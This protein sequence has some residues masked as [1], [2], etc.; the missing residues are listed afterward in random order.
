[1]PDKPKS[2][3]GR[4]ST[5]GKAEKPSTLLENARGVSPTPLTHQHGRAHYAMDQHP[6]P[7]DPWEKPETMT[8]HISPAFR[9]GLRRGFSAHIGSLFGPRKPYPRP[10]GDLLHQAW[11]D[12][13]NVLREAT[14]AEARRHAKTTQ[15]REQQDRAKPTS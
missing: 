15:N 2:G 3:G 12:V 1:M 14:E 6:P 8:T 7:P 4:H 11:A 5:G 10:R 13:G 9:A